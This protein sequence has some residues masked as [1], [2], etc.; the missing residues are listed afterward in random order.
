MA[1]KTQQLTI[2]GFLSST[3]SAPSSS[4][5]PSSVESADKSSSS[6]EECGDDADSEPVTKKARRSSV[7]KHRVSGFNPAWKKDFKWLESST[8]DGKTGMRCKLCA[9]HGKSPRNGKGSWTTNPCFS[10]RRDKILKHESSAMHKAAL[11]AAAEASC[12]DIP[13]KFKDA[14]TVEMQAAVGCCKCIYWLCKHEISHTTTYPHLLSLAESLGCRYFEALRVGRNAKYTSPQI[15]GEFLEI[16]DA[17]VNEAVLHDIK[18]CKFFSIMVDESTDV[19]VQKQLVLYGRT[20]VEGRLSTRFLKLI[21]LADGKAFTITQSLVA[22]LQSVELSIDSLS[23]FGSDGAAVMT[24]RRS[25]VAARLCEM[26]AQIIPVHCICHRLAL[27]TGQASNEVPYLKKMKEYLLA[28]WKFF[29]YSPVRAAGLKLIQEAMCLPELKMLKGVDTRWL[30]HKA[31]VSAL[32]RSLPAILV[33]LQQQS[34]PTALGLYKVA[35]RY[36][37]FASLLLLNDVLSAVNRLS[38]AFQR[39]NID[40]TI[41]NP[42][43]QSTIVTIE[44]LQ[45]VSPTEFQTKV[46]QLIDKTCVEVQQMHQAPPDSEFCD[47]QP[48]EGNKCVTVRTNEPE[49]YE[50]N[51]RQPFLTKLLTNLMERFPN[52]DVIEAFSVLDPAGLFGENEVAKEHLD[53]LLN[54]YSEDGGPMGI[55]KESC[56]KEYSEFISFTEK[57]A[58]LKG[59]NSLQELAENVLSNDSTKELFPLVAQLMLHALVLPVSTTDCERCFSTMNRVKTELRNRMNTTTLDRLLRVR[60]EGPEDF[61][62]IEAATRWSRAKKRRLFN[63]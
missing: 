51:V 4:G 63:S 39:A 37:V 13:R 45:K 38:M 62:H 6:S 15:V 47:E 27:A 30:S 55:S 5:A 53:V 18:K 60:I 42:L 23:S 14:E 8:V 1:T 26:N 54:H 12:G 35:T 28:F 52:C 25:G 57:H 48:V 43:L 7:K 41:I 34:E 16:I 10:L 59:C 19:G 21:D 49:S 2:E 29:H 31:S 32:L 40:F 44:K 24:G 11:V 17:I 36:N 20:V 50:V 22:Y 9:K 46:I 33:T 58:I 56:T 3:N 61:P